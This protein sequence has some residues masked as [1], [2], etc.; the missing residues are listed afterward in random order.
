MGLDPVGI[1]AL[2]TMAQKRSNPERRAR[3]ET[4][5]SQQLIRVEAVN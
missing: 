1:D 5:T 2:K 3:L 4:I